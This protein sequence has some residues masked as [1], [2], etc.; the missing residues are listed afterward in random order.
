MASSNSPASKGSHSSLNSHPEI[1]KA[2]AP[3]HLE[4]PAVDSR[5][6]YFVQGHLDHGIMLQQSVNLERMKNTPYRILCKVARIKYLAACVS[7]DVFTIMTLLPLSPG[8]TVNSDS[9]VNSAPPLIKKTYLLSPAEEENGG[10]RI[11]LTNECVT[12]FFPEAS[13]GSDQNISFKDVHGDEWKFKLTWQPGPALTVGL[14]DFV[15]AKRLKA[16]DFVVLMRDDVRD[17]ELRVGIR[18][19][20]MLEAIKKDVHKVEE[21]AEL[22]AK[23]KR[24]RVSYYPCYGTPEFVVSADRVDEAM[25]V[26]TELGIRFVM[27]FEDGDTLQARTCVGVVKSVGA[28]DAERWP[29]SPWK[30]LQVEFPPMTSNETRISPWVV[31]KH[32]HNHGEV[33]QN[34]LESVEAVDCGS[35]LLARTKSFNGEKAPLMVKKVEFP[36][37]DGE[38][39][40]TWISKAEQY[41][42]IKSTRSVDKLIKRFIGIDALNRYE[43]L[44]SLKQLGTMDEFVNELVACVF[45]T[46][47]LGNDQLL[48]YFLVGIKTEIRVE[49]QSSKAAE[50]MA[51]MDG[52]RCVE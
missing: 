1:W 36:D 4:I 13:E 6:Y 16:G 15:R 8:E 27:P 43:H 44:S 51:A 24:F 28:C 52:A 11:S 37:F 26:P 48:G 39:V 49:L 47:G 7:D 34:P 38:E 20:K 21:A 19:G 31:I 5:V 40:L 33:C 35:S 50:L 46:H 45:H 29:D 25:K 14:K 12:T 3:E 30:S 18:R 42:T 22:A 2:C 17:G 41:F 9:E 23:G 10:C 32:L